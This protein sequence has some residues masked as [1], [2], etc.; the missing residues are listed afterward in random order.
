MIVFPRKIR[1]PAEFNEFTH[2]SLL[3]PCSR[4]E[5]YELKLSKTLTS[6]ANGK[7]DLYE[8]TSWQRI[9]PLLEP[10]RKD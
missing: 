3:E 5:D 6:P 8:F 7:G 4:A 1:P 10:A 9:G 2:K